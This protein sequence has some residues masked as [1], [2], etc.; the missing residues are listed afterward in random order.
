MRT[1]G[2]RACL[3]ILATSNIAFA[4][5][6]LTVGPQGN[7]ARYRVREQLMGIDFPSDALGKTTNVEGQIV[8]GAKGNVVQD[9]S[10]FTI[11]LASLTSDKNM[12]DNYVRR[13]MLQTDSFA[14]ALF[15]P[16]ELRNVKL[17]LPK[18]GDIAFQILGNLTV[19]GVTKPVTWDVVAKMNNGALQGEAKTKFTFADFALE[20]PKVRSVLSVEDDIA[21]EYTF[22]LVPAKP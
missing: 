6:R 5:T 16:T 7:E 15:V 3:L 19:R 10:R 11:D 17:P 13:R 18:S 2:L 22:F 12:R 14:T 8:V 21:L 20:K 9:Q 1:V 4:Q